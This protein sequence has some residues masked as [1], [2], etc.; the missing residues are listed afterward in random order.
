VA[1][2]SV[3]PLDLVC[4]LKV[5]PAESGYFKAV[6][7]AIFESILGACKAIGTELAFPEILTPTLIHLKT[8][9]KKECKN[10]EV[11]KKYKGLIEKVLL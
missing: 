1:K 9:L 7:E 10:G 5:D 11:S 6:S 4:C 3:R 8:F 2:F